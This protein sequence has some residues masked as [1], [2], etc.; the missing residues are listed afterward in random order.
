M[1]TS[2]RLFIATSNQKMCFSVC[3]ARCYWPILVSRRFWQPP[4]LSIQK[5]LEHQHIWLRNNFAAW[6][7]KRVT[8][9]LWLALLMSCLL[10]KNHSRLP[11]L[12]QW[13]LNM[14]QSRLLLP[15]KLIRAYL[16]ILSKLSSKG[17]QKSAT[18]VIPTSTHLLRRYICPLLLFRYCHRRS[19]N[20]L[21]LCQSRRRVGG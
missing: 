12:W 8:S 11:I 15:D 4:A 6:S 13:V 14:P 18:N 17:W 9:M 7:V 19:W 21:P 2:S 3:R 16:N 1:L 5:P 20:R 10:D